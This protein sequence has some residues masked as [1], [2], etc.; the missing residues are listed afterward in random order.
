MGDETPKYLNSPETPVFYKGQELYGLFQARKSVR[1]LE[2][3]LVVEGYMDVLALAQF[4]IRNV[5]ATLGTATTPEHLQRLFRAVPEV[6]FCFDG[7]RAGRAAAWR[8]MENSLPILKEGR[9]VRFM[10][11]PG[12]EDPD[13]LV[14]KEGREGFERR[15]TQAA[16]FSDFLYEGLMEK[17]DIGTDVG[18]AQLVELARPYLSKIQ[19][20]VLRY[21]MITRLADL[22]KMVPDKLETLLNG[23][24]SR[25]N[26]S[27]PKKKTKKRT[28][29]DISLV[30]KAMLLLLHRP[31]LASR[32]GEPQQFMEI[33]TRGM[34]L[35]IQLLDL[36]QEKPHLNCAAILEQHSDDENWRYL[37]KLAQ[38]TPDL[39]PEL[40]ESEFDGILT[41]LVEEQDQVRMD[42]LTSKPFHELS[43]EEKIEIRQG[44]RLKK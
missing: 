12:G 3:L 32:A 36:L 5:V 6:V 24:T 40:Y 8:A 31:E 15:I 30:G 4:D 33:Q 17:A 38:I 35:L 41:K 42:A 14:R 13:S 28:W 18:K 27:S 37:G 21:M 9:V 22:L 2:R 44:P 43:E 29:V 26:P 34:D 19:A 16:T 7:D 20:S 23:S 1:N 39:P 25:E 10:F 11:L